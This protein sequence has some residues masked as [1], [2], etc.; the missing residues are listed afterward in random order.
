MNG[1]FSKGPAG[2]AGPAWHARRIAPI[3]V[4]AVL[5][6]LAFWGS[7]YLLSIMILIMCYM[8]IGQMW[9]LL[10]G[11][12]GLVSL[13]QQS[14]IGLGG[15]TLAKITQVYH[16]PVILAFVLAAVISV[17]FALLISIPVFKMKGVYFT[18]GTWI[19]AECLALFFST[20][21]FSNYAQG[22][23]ITATYAFS[24]AQIYLVALAVGVGALIV[25]M[26]VLRSRLGLAL[27]AMRDN[28]A[29]SEVRGV[30]QYRT[31]L[32]CFLIS[33]AVTGIAGAALYLNQA[34][35]QPANAFGISWTVS[36]VFIA[37]IGGMGTVEGPIIGAVIFVLLRQ[38]LYNF[39]GISMMLLG[40]IAIAIIMI[41]PRGI[42]G[43]IRRKTQFEIFPV[44]RH[45][46]A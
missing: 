10:G 45:P 23:T 37:I 18:I 14:F 2:M 33:A 22:Y 43:I 20:W 1:I 4:L 46:S 29:A 35:I 5:V 8:A 25:V 17:L 36:M 28:A 42:M 41:A 30:E 16:L 38:A 40:L 7:D 9:N 39:P 31:K 34:F 12:A 15:Y 21:S 27:M 24:T 19:V 13:G 11:Y 44:R 6:S 26:A 3:A 32:K